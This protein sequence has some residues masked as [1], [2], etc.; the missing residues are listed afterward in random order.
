MEMSTIF[1]NSESSKTSGVY[2]LKLNLPNKMDLPEVIIVLCFHTL[3]STK[4]G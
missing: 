4:H 2:L 1:M 3:I